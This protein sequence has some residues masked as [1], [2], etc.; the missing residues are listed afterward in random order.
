MLRDITRQTDILMAVGLIGLIGIMMVPLPPVLLDLLL[1]TNLALALS[2]LLLSM[3][4]RRPLDFS[5]LP[6][7]LLVTTLFRLALNISSTRLILLHASAGRVIECFG[8]FVVGGDLL[9][10]SVIFL[11]LVVIQFVV[12]TNGSGRVAEVAARFTLDEMPGKQMSI[13]ADLN[14]GLINENQARE[15]RHDIEREA[16]FYGAMDGASKFVKGDAIAGIVIVAVNII[17]GLAIGAGRLGMPLGD[18]LQRYALLTI[19]DGL[20]SQLPALLISTATGIVVTRSASENDL[21]NEVLGQLAAYPRA[22]GIVGAMLLSF[23][24]VPGLPKFSFLLLGGL[25]GLAAWQLD[26]KHKATAQS[27]ELPPEALPPEGEE[28]AVP[29]GVDRLSLEIGFGLIG[30]LEDRSG[31]GLLSR[32]T[33]LRRQL[34]RELGLPVPA[35]RV[36]DDLGLEPNEYV[37][38]LRGTQRARGVVRPGSLLAIPSRPDAAPLPGDEAREPVFDLPA[39]WINPDQRLQ[40]E[41]RGYTV[42]E[43]AA[44]MATHLSETV[45]RHAAEVLSR[46]DVAEMIERVRA[47]EP[48]VINELVPE[49]ATVGQ[50]HLSLRELLAEGLSLRDLT[51]ILETYADGLRLTGNPEQAVERVRASQAEA[52]CEQLC[53][54]DGKLLAVSVSPALEQVIEESVIQTAEGPLCAL[55]PDL[56]QHI[57]TELAGLL[58]ELA[59]EG[60]EA[61]L[62]TSPTS[63]RLVR[64]ALVRFFP[65]VRIMSYAELA[66]RVPVSILRQLSL[67][68]SPAMSIA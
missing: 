37:I 62:L 44:V 31:P 9:V 47:Q 42:V 38:R 46:Q 29:E 10:G 68:S 30:L 15:R 49:L 1:A 3:Y 26:R 6:S 40:A 66:P 59:Q 32:I 54:S 11:I 20:V 34:S 50:V 14:A 61:V 36:R 41:T 45:R 57:N 33:A 4:V 39:W 60:R 12:I 21:G 43:P 8:E 51:A 16:D 23:G 27:D 25:A 56:L 55:A 17:G 18:A 52:L 28:E 2:I 13:D 64:S 58:S 53:G 5:V 48:A 19:G 35:V 63:R 24:F 65:Q 22:L 7:L 67:P